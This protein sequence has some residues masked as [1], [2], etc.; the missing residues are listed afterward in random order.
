[1]SGIDWTQL[2]SHP[3]GAF[4][5][6]LDYRRVK[7]RWVT[8]LGLLTDFHVEAVFESLQPSPERY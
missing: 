3:A 8:P 7:V 4:S 1:L 5:A 2:F 6:T